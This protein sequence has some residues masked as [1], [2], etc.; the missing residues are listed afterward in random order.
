MLPVPVA[1]ITISGIDALIVVVYLAAVTWMGI[2]IGRGSKNVDDYLLGDRS[3]PWWAVLG[4]IVATETSTATFLSVPGVAFARGG[5]FQF[6]QL[7]MGY[8]IGRIIV[9]VW[10]LPLYFEGRL[11]TAYEVLHNRFGGIVQKTASLIFLLTRNVGDGLRLFLTAIV[12]REVTGV[13]LTA[14]IVVVGLCTVAY[15]FVGGMKAVVWSDCVQ[16]VIYL[17]GGIA[18]LLLMV[19][20]LPG[21]WDGLLEFAR[22]ENKLSVFNP[23]INFTD[24]HTLLAGLIGGA[25]LTLGTHG[26]DQMMVQRYLCTRGRGDAAKALIGSGLV[27]FCQFVLFLSI[28]V[29]L[30]AWYRQF[31]PDTVLV[32]DQEFIHFIVHHM[33]AG[34]VG[35]TIAAVFSAAMSTL[36]SS[37]NSSAGA[38]V[39]DFLRSSGSPES[40][41]RLT[42]T[43]TLVFGLVQMLI[44]IGFGLLEVRQNLVQE[45][46]AVAG[47]SS[48]VLVG[49]FALGVL[50]QRVDQLS[51]VCGM[52]AATAAL[53]SVKFG[54]PIAWPW[55]TPIGASVTIVVGLFVSLARSKH[56]GDAHDEP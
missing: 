45:V 40:Q 34:L 28:G 11:F 35:F 31:S 53:V 4:S 56:S 26:T 14:S 15:T 51:A 44:A 29:A 6:L 1:A 3:L 50:T 23:A 8:L 2:R 24:K 33:P 39:S 37:L 16:L 43:L 19:Q 12:V 25:L 52:V 20:Q 18:A 9:A 42:Q 10:L 13:G 41:L 27:V 55:Y 17:T 47:F 5:N 22:S 38:V 30:A 7:V 36:S 54:T 46:L 21:G 49:V 32:K 48:G